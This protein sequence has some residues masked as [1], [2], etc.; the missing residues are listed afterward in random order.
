LTEILNYELTAIP[1]LT[2]HTLR[3]W[4]ADVIHIDVAAKPIIDHNT[5]YLDALDTMVALAKSNSAYTV[6]SMRYEYINDERIYPTQ[7]I[8][9]GIAVLSG[10]S[11]N[12]PAVLYVLGSEPREISWSDLKPRLT[13]MLDAPRANNPRSIG[14]LPGTEWSR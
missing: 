3:G 12:E 7:L 13:T 6:M 11:S 10:R 9:D 8:E 14:F 5:K 2:S 4:S 1:V